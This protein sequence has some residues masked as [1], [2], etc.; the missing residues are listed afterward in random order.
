[1]SISDKDLVDVALNSLLSYLKEKLEG[2]DYYNLNAMQLRA[3]NQEYKI[4]NSKDA[5]KPHHSNTH[6]VEYDSILRMMRIMRF[7]LLSLFG[8][9]RPNLVLVHRLSRLRRVGK[10]RWNLHLMSPNVIVFLMSC[11]VLGIL[12]SIMLYRRLKS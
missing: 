10:K 6:I 12:R 1:M 8:H 7:T 9:H 3:T 2:F 11:C 4:K 5:Y